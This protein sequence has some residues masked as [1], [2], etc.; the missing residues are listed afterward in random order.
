MS[1]PLQRRLGDTP[2]KQPAPVA[3]IVKGYPRL[4]ETFIAQEIYNLE[5]RGLDIQIYSLRPPRE[6]DRHPVHENI[7]APIVYLPERLRD[8]PRL[9]AGALIRQ[10]AT[11]AGWRAAGKLLRDLRDDPSLDRLRR[12]GQAAVLTQ[13]LPSEVRHLHAHFLH[14]PASVARYAATMS[15]RTWSCSAHAKDIWTLG[16]AEKQRKLAE[17]TWAVT[18]TATGHVHLSEL[19]SRP[20]DVFLAYHGLDLAKFPQP[21]DHAPG[22]NGRASHAPAML[23]SVG[24][25]VR[26]KGFDVLLDALARLPEDLHWRWTHI[27]AGEEIAK[28]REQ[29]AALKLTD[30]IDFRGPRT[31]ADVLAAYRAADV[32]VL[33]SRITADGDRDGL[34]NV[35]M[36]AMSQE[37]ACLSTPI[38]GIPELIRNGCDGILVAAED[39]SALASALAQLIAD[40]ERRAGLGAEGRRTVVAKFSPDHGLRLLSERFGL[41]AAAQP[42]PAQGEAAFAPKTPT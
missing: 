13:A 30:R 29:A 24:R 40:P 27:G 32:F 34:P 9:V 35:L 37:L 17:S 18:C 25:A 39:A 31:Q 5:Q 41:N 16:D 42:T 15:G 23:L 20:D 36:E 26:K 38:S 3:F 10:L 11:L 28:L 22:P 6:P 8:A 19:S 2:G 33:P 21:A 4:S 1:L 7:Q 12:F 14:T